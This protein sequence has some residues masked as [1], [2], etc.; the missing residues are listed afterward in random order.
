[1]NDAH[2]LLTTNDK[3][4]KLWKVKERDVHTVIENNQSLN[5]KLAQ[6]DVSIPIT[7]PKTMRKGQPAITAAP[8]RVYPNAHAYHIHSISTSPDGEIFLSADD[9]RINIWDLNRSDQSFNIVDLKP[10]NIEALKEVIT[11]TTFHPCHDH[12]FAYST[13]QASVRLGDMRQSALCDRHAKSR[14][15]PFHILD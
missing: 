11:S 7:L 9:L 1:V 6:T 15:Y 5:H 2:F 14:L 13:S 12:L 4:V 8:K 3:T 10:P